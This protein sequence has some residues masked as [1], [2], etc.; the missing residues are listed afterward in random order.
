MLRSFDDLVHLIEGLGLPH[1]AEPEQSAIEVG[2]RIRGEPARMVI[3]WDPRA[4]LLHVIHPLPMPTPAERAP[5]LCEA[6]AR[7]NHALVM[8]GFGWNPQDGGLYYK[9]VVPRHPDGALPSED[10]DRAVRTVLASV[11]DLLPALRAV[12][13]GADPADV[14]T[15]AE[16][17]RV[18]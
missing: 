14:L 6:I 15:I 13:S 1:H 12:A 9:L 8:P 16:A 5:A 4:T 3:V 18:V 11:R 7:V 17:T 10:A 2:T